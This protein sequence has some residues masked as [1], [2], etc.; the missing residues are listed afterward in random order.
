MLFTTV[1]DDSLQG[2]PTVNATY[3][4]LNAGGAHWNSGM[5]EKG[6]VVYMHLQRGG[7]IHWLAPNK[8][9]EVLRPAGT[10]KWSS[11]TATYV[12]FMGGLRSVIY[13]SSSACKPYRIYKQTWTGAQFWEKLDSNNSFPSK[14][15]EAWNW[16][17]RFCL[18]LHLKL[19]KPVLPRSTWQKR[20]QELLQE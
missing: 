17:L 7:E 5:E 1:Q 8:L 3:V 6:K 15:S 13:K 9:V 4:Q 12:A 2:N 16:C 20:M 14:L 19:R 10:G 11:A 18:F